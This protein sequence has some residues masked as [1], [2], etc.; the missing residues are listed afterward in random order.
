M[1]RVRRSLTLRREEFLFDVLF[2]LDRADGPRRKVRGVDAARGGQVQGARERGLMGRAEAGWI[3][4]ATGCSA[5][6]G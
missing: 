5:D 3:E 6:W 1:E 2:V 4:L